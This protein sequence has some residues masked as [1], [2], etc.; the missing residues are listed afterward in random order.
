MKKYE[1]PILT[2]YGNLKQITKVQ[3]PSGVIL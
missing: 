2:R 1:T 3:L